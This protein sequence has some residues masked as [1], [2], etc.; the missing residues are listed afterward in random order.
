MTEKK[1]LKVLFIKNSGEAKTKIE[2]NKAGIERY[3]MLG[4]QLSSNDYDDCA[5]L[6]SKCFEDYFNGKAGDKKHSDKLVSV[7]KIKF[8]KSTV[9]RR[10][11]YVPGIK[12]GFIGLTNETIWLLEKDPEKLYEVEVSGANN[13]YGYYHFYRNHPNMAIRI[14]Y[15]MAIISLVIGVLGFVLSI[16]QL[17]FK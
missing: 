13:L 16:I 3:L 17:F 14:G 6:Y 9:Y 7:L 5:V 8:G 4:N 11:R 10:F 2:C 15:I 1:Q 12:S